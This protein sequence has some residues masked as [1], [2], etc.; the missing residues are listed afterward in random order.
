VPNDERDLIER[1]AEASQ[2]LRKVDWRI[3]ELL[4]IPVRSL[5]QK[6]DDPKNKLRISKGKSEKKERAD[7]D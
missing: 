2:L 6:Q 5:E 3:H 1:L 4:V 7:S